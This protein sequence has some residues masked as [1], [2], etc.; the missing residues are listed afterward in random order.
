MVRGQDFYAIWDEKAGVWSTDE[1]DVQRLVDEDLYLYAQN[2]KETANA[3]VMVKYMG[4]F[5][6]GSWTTFQRYLKSV[7]DSSHQLDEN[8][9]FK[10]TV[11][12]KSDYVSKRL[13]Y[14][15]EQ[16]TISA[17]DE[18]VS[19][20]YDPE[21]RDKLEWT[22]G[23]VV[24]GE[25]KDIQ[26]FAV[27]Y[28]SAGTGKSTMLNIIQDLF[29]G[30]FTVFEAKALTGSNN[31]FATEAFRTNP[32]V[33]IQHDGDLSKIEDNTKLNSI[34]SHEQMVMNEKYKASYASRINAFLYMGTN[35]AVKITDAKSGIIRRLIDI[36]P[37]GRRVTPQR[38]QVLNSQIQFELGGIAKH[39]LDTYRKLGRDYYA[40]YEPVEMM[41][42][43]DVFYNYIEAYFDYFNENDG[44]T[45][46]QAY[47]MYKQF[48]EETLIEYRLPQYRFREELKNY[49]LYFE[50]RARVEGVRV[51]SYYYGF[52]SERFDIPKQEQGYN[53]LVLDKTVS[54]VDDV[55]S[56]CPAQYANQYETPSAKWSEVET[57]L[58]DLDT[59]KL[60]YVK[61]PGDHI[62]IDFD[63]KDDEG[64]K[65]AQLN[66]E[67]ASKWPPTYAEY[68]K[69]G[70]GVHLHYRYVGDTSELSRIFSENVEIKVFVGDSSLRRRLSL[71]NELP[72]AT[73]SGGLPLKEKKVI[74]Q[75]KLKSEKALRDLIWRNLR[76]EIHPGTKPSVDFIHKI[77]EDAYS[78]DLEYDVED[79]R[80]K[81]LTFATRSTNQ[82]LYCI[83]LVNKM[84][85]KSEEK[86]ENSSVEASDEKPIVIF[87]CEV[88]PNLFLVSWK[89]QGTDTKCT[90]MINP[91]PSEIEEFI[92]MRLVG[93]NNR[94]YDNHILYGALMGYNNRQLFEL[95]KKIVSGDRHASFGEAY[96]LSYTDVYDFASKKQSL[97]KWEIE[98]G[99]HHQEMDWPWDQPI[100]EEKWGQV[101]DYCDNDVYA[102]DA[103]FTSRHGD[104]IAREILA[105]ISGLTVNDTTN[106]HTTKI[107]LGANKRNA[108]EQYIYTD[109]SEMFPGYMFESGKSSYRGEDPGEGGY[110]Y[111]EEGMY[112]D[113]A[114][115]DIASMHPTSMVE[116]NIFGPYT[117]NLEK[118]MNARLAIKHGEFDSARKMFNGVLA[119]YLKTTEDAKMLSQALKIAINS[120][121][122]LTS[123]S[124]DHPLRDIR[125]VDNIV[126][127][128]GAL[129]MIDL[130]H[131]VQERGFTVAHIKTDSIKIPNATKE[132]IDEVMEFG[133]Q[134]GYTFEHEATYEKMCLVNKAVYIAKTKQG[135]EPAYWTATGAQ[136]QEPYV[137]KTMFTKEPIEFRDLCVA[138]SVTTSLYLDFNADKMLGGDADEK[139]H[140]V[141]KTGLFCPMK[142][143]TGGGALLRYNPDKDTYSSAT[144]ATGYLW[145]E[146]EMVEVLEKKDDIDM[147]YFEGLV[148]GAFDNISKY[149]DAE[150]FLD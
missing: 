53:S 60:H 69:G 92:N 103:V 89:T 51:R 139:P 123:A 100:P 65:S 32:L 52:K 128:R 58:K 39:C 24:S 47:T 68:S 83:K 14:N 146:S 138:K 11:V 94:K 25:A 35:K 73:I 130:K 17:Y 96:N 108:H 76:K 71:C 66:I 95:S 149:G 34:V 120:V 16:T 41:L 118:L 5:S 107:L 148:N 98:L 55:Y 137:F 3:H 114:L 109:L 119:P 40:G 135:R 1:Y 12:K 147:S 2:L 77:L 56:D 8:L 85:F 140:F 38:Y 116:L 93:F 43:T 30:Y 143:G 110:V 127:K 134:Y 75:D 79:L 13:P 104:F 44:V 90:R 129:F 72:V 6:S 42:Q 31:A 145:M 21:E 111:V 106:A 62:V 99:L 46:V 26:K 91:S 105:N 29:Q 115:L 131:F 132:I 18:L 7:S 57:T 125:N 63:L 122:G 142:P 50:E 74:N 82:S 84:K 113:V 88:Y 81:V 28:G 121:Y 102:T 23:A 70:G 49:F 10:N 144:G 141:G 86:A 4:D 97:K 124:F 78:S 150:R 61:P 101:G 33:A 67:A 15:L 112:E 45:L 59:S 117:E 27:L 37:S 36:H 19:T 136:F 22:I 133:L 80:P 48:C 126:A 64:N 20:L 54:L 9:T 87:D